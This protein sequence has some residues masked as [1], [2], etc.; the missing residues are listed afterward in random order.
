MDQNEISTLNTL[1]HK[2]ILSQLQEDLQTLPA[3]E[4]EVFQSYYFE[5]LSIREI[6]VG[7]D[8]FA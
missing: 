8:D 4:K 7:C 6:A 2:D 5:E 1:I 3:K